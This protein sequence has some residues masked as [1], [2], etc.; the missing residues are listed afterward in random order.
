M[1]LKILFIG[2]LVLSAATIAP[3]VF[4]LNVPLPV[5][6]SGTETTGFDALFDDVEPNGD[7]VGSG[8]GGPG[9]M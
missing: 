7:P 8:G 9:I 3:V 1:K 6:I 5:S 4:A 2:L